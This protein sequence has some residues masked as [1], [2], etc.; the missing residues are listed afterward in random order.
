MRLRV[1]RKLLSRETWSSGYKVPTFTRAWRRVARYERR[2]YVVVDSAI[3]PCGCMHM[4]VGWTL[5][6]EHEPPGSYAGV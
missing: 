3:L 6:R 2:R 5:C 1:A 4:G